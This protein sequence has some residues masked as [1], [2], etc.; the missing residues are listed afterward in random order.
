MHLLNMITSKYCHFRTRSAALQTHRQTHRQT[1]RG[2][3]V[4]Q[5]EVRGQTS[6]LRFPGDSR[7]L[8]SI[9]WSTHTPQVA[10]LYTQSLQSPWGPH[11][12]CMVILRLC[13]V[14]CSANFVYSIAL[15]LLHVMQA[16]VSSLVYFKVCAVY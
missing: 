7:P 10:P 12:L 14:K 15:K 16:F 1:Q 13:T 8:P 6:L 9:V 4:D 2:W 5:R 3:A 11:L